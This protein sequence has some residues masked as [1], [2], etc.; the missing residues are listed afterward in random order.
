MECC[1]LPLVPWEKHHCGMCDKVLHG[2][3]GAGQEQGSTSRCMDCCRKHGVPDWAMHPA[4]IALRKEQRHRG[5][6][7]NRNPVPIVTQTQP[8][9]L[10]PTTT[11]PNPTTTR[12]PAA[13]TP[14]AN[15][16]V[17]RGP[18]LVGK[19]PGTGTNGKKKRKPRKRKED[20]PANVGVI[21][22]ADVD[23]ERFA[24]EEPE[25]I[26]VDPHYQYHRCLIEFM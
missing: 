15:I 8:T 7:P 22:N 20:E 25:V 11:N 10:Q 9:T 18:N 21:H 5:F 1:C 12:Q 3:C 26:A 13:A 2:H 19:D 24:E 23:D 17:N 14:L 4:A 6:T 16:P